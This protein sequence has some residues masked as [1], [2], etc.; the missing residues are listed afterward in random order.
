MINDRKDYLGLV[1]Q[2]KGNIDISRYNALKSVNKIAL[3]LYFNT[4]GMLSEKV[5]NVKWGSK[6]LK[7]LSNDIQTAYPGIRGF[8]LQNLKN[9]RKFYDTYKNL[10]E[11]QCLIGQNFS[12]QNLDLKILN[13]PNSIVQLPTAQLE[14][15]DKSLTINNKGIMP[16]ATAQ[17]GNNE[18]SIGQLTTVQLENNETSYFIELFLSIGFTQHLLLIQKCK[19]LKEP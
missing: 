13:N 17:L 18:N 8:A 16:L 4:G 2:M 3:L 5:K 12:L 1:K 15:R 10:P 14:K 7:Q 11:C 9:M 6:V 19:D